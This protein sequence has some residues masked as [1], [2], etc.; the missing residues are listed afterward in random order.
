MEKTEKFI[1]ATLLDAAQSTSIFFNPIRVFV[2]ANEQDTVGRQLP[3]SYTIQ[4]VIIR[5]PELKDAVIAFA[6]N[7]YGETILRVRTA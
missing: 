6:D 5:N 2:L 7:Y 3:G 4:Q 1:G